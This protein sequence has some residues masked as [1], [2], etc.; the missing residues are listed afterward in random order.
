VRSLVTG[1]ARVVNRAVAAR[2]GGGAAVIGLIAA[3]LLAVL[4]AP[5]VRDLGRVWAEIPYYSYGFLVPVFAAYLVWD[6]RRTLHLDAAWR[7]GALA[8]VAAG[9]VVLGLGVATASLMLRALSLPLVGAGLARA[10]L[11][12]PAFRTVVFPIAFLAFM[13][14]LPEGTLPA[15]SLPLQQL[16]AW[17]TEHALRALGIPVHRDGLLL[18]LDRVI[19]HVSEACNGLRFLLAMAVLGVAFAWATQRH[20]GHRVVVVA[21]AIVLAI[22]ANLVRVIGTGVLAELLGPEAAA[23]MFHVVYGKVV[24]AAVLGPFLLA[25]LLLGR[26]RRQATVGR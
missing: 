16:A 8:L 4:Y 6:A 15:L 20:A 14:P 23:G 22:V 2:R 12:G 19:L 13:A 3:A 25:L 21:A 24:Y 9:L 26:R 18:Y 17:T 11:E 5:V 10:L 1:S 7:P